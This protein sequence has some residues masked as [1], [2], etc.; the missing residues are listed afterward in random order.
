MFVVDPRA[1]LN[2][3]RNIL[4]NKAKSVCGSSCNSNGTSASSWRRRKQCWVQHAVLL[5]AFPQIARRS[6]AL[7]A[8]KK[9]DQTESTPV[10]A[11]DVR[12]KMHEYWYPPS[13]PQL[14]TCK[15]RAQRLSLS[16]SLPLSLALTLSLS[17]TPSHKPTKLTNPLTH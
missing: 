8:K 11:A 14:N 5:V 10:A 9:I 4:H 15:H 6:D 13:G 12:K 1:E 16:S 2:S 17:P 7:C 3:P